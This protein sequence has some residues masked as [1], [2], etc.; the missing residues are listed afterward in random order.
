[1]IVVC[2][3]GRSYRLEGFEQR[4]SHFLSPAYGIIST[5]SVHHACSEFNRQ[6]WPCSFSRL[7][8][9]SRIQLFSQ[10][11][12]RNPL[13]YPNAF[14]CLLACSP[15]SSCCSVFWTTSPGTDHRMEGYK[16]GGNGSTVIGMGRKFSERAR[17]W[18]LPT[19][20]V[21]LY[22]VASLSKGGTDLS[23]GLSD[24]HDTS[25]FRE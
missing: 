14:I 13:G 6:Q 1:M 5:T 21:R 22:L 15:R 8:T 17:Y 12:R 18:Y 24:G 9:L 23:L 20:L 10:P 25:W 11:C 19:T 7:S 4:S 3:T 16:N 2:P